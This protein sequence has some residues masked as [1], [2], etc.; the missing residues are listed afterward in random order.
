MFTI[1]VDEK[2]NTFSLH[3]TSPVIIIISKSYIAH[4]YLPN[5][6]LKAEYTV[7]KLSER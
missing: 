2:G 6:V 4:K 3:E 7:Y 1:D 5:K